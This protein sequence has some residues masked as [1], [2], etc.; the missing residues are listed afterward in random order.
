MVVSFTYGDR[1]LNGI[2]F[3]DKWGAKLLYLRSIDNT[4]ETILYDDER[5]VGIVSRN[6]KKDLN[7]L[8]I[9]QIEKLH[10]SCIKSSKNAQLRRDLK[11]KD[12]VSCK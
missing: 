7:R 5:I 8:I 4:V 9:S 11:S 3:Y 6:E 12:I 1:N 10:I 2:V